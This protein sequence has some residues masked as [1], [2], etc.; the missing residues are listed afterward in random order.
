MFMYL[1]HKK[2]KHVKTQGWSHLAIWR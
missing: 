1:K 2:T